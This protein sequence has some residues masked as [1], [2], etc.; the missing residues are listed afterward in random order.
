MHRRAV[1]LVTVVLLGV[2][3][4]SGDSDGADDDSVTPP[5]SVSV[6]A[7]PALDDESSDSGSN[8]AAEPADSTPDVA[9]SPGSVEDFCAAISAIQSADF[10]LEETFGPDAR[11]LFD[12]VRSAAPPDVA[13]DVMTVIETLDA[14]AELGISLDDDDPIAFKA[15]SEILFDP[16]FTEA[17]ANLAAYT[18]DACGIELDA[19][20]VDADV[21]LDD[22]DETVDA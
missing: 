18:S 22:I 13:S 8:D 12:D 3:A 4:C 1:P 5:G 20:D 6:E 11:I 10:E 15:A 2:A 9:T 17:N 7:A 14:I 16:D 21:Q 19:G